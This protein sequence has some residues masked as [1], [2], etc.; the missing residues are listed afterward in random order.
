MSYLPNDREGRVKISDFMTT[1]INSPE[2]FK[3]KIESSIAGNN[4]ERVFA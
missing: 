4:D 1:D 3:V 2:A